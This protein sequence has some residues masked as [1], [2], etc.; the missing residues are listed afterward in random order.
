MKH[1]I[2]IC[3]VVQSIHVEI[4]CRTEFTSSKE[5]CVPHLERKFRPSFKTMDNVMYIYRMCPNGSSSILERV[6]QP[7]GY[8]PTL[9]KST[10]VCPSVCPRTASKDFSSAVTF[11]LQ[12]KLLEGNPEA[13]SI[14][15]A[16]C[17]L[18]ELNTWYR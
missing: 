1:P 8:D 5:I 12:N 14:S 10:C 13:P 2:S 11:H 16:G 15:P 4:S 9:G 6:K 7:S 18:W 17:Q 3:E